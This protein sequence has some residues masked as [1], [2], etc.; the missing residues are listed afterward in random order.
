MAIENLKKHL[1]IAPLIFNI[2]FWLYK[3][4]PTPTQEKKKRLVPN[5][6]KTEARSLGKERKP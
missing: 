2:A 3:P 4:N 1:I 5:T 6:V